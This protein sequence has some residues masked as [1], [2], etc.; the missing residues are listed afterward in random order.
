M[1]KKDRGKSTHARLTLLSENLNLAL[2]TTVDHHTLRSLCSFLSLLL[3]LSA[4][5]DGKRPVANCGQ[6]G[7]SRRGSWYK[8]RKYVG[9]RKE[10]RPAVAPKKKTVAQ[11]SKPSALRKVSN[12]AT[13]LLTDIKVAVLV[14][15]LSVQVVRRTPARVD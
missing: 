3:V 2:G 1:G 12:E 7:W 4:L 15:Y 8:K 6:A 5:S 13:E 10:D 14:L 11:K 9:I